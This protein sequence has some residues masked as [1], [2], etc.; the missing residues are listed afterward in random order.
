MLNLLLNAKEYQFDVKKI[1]RKLRGIERLEKKEKQLRGRCEVFTKQTAK[2]KDILP[3]VEEIAA[4]HIDMNE[5][6]A[7]KAAIN[8]AVEL[9]NLPPLTATLRLIE[10]IKKFERLGGLEQEL[11]RLFLQKYALV[12]ACSRQSQL[13]L[14]LGK[15]QNQA[16]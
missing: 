14:A 8:Q 2:Y 4:L 1:A 10:D 3:L 16:L 12:Q 6:I 5:L 15:M 11:R 9:Y 7:F 13:L